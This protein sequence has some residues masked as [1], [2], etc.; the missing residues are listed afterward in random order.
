M[1]FKLFTSSCVAAFSTLAI[2][3]TS[4]HA[5]PGDP[6]RGGSVVIPIHV[7]EPATYDCHATNSPAVMWRVSP[8]YSTLLKVN[9]ERS[10][11]VMGDLAKSWTVSSDHLTYRFTL[12][13]NVK[14]HDGSLLTST[15]V[16]ASFDRMRNPPQ[17]V[18]SLR[19]GM[20]ADIASIETPDPQTV[21]FKFSKLNA[22]ALQLLA[23]PFGCI[24]SAKLLA[25][26]ASYPG[27]RVVGSGPFKF[28]RHTPGAEWV[29]E[30]FDDYFMPGRPYL[31]GFR[32][33]SVAPVSATNALI[34]GQVNYTMQGLTSAEVGRVTAARGDKVVVVGGAS[35]TAFLPWFAMNTQRDGLKDER[36]RRAL[37]L[38]LDRWGSSKPMEQLTPMF[39]VGGLV[40]PGSTFARSDAELT[41]LPGFGRDIEAARKESRRLLAAAG[42]KNLKITLVNNRA[43]TFFGV[44]VADQLRQVGVT[45]DH[46]PLDTPQV[47]AR[48]V[49]GD[50]DL[51]FD[52][53]AEYVDDPSIQLS[54]FE[55]FSTNRG[56]LARVGDP[57]F[58]DK[59]QSQMREINAE[60]RRKKVQD[61]EAYLME[62]S[63]VMPLFWQVRK[64]VIDSQLRGLGDPPS[65]Y[66]KLDLNDIWLDTAA[67]K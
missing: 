8:H 34:S 61:L 51:I 45:V 35:A 7:G 6:V 12:N 52:S 20:L 24:Y 13:A 2:C 31:D 15:D 50:Y 28:V 60:S 30:R 49:S 14:F 36:V 44:F 55:P 5:A 17:G 29:G 41:K 16:K 53:P 3:A 27:K 1:N 10:P 25:S 40:R 57:T 63:Y 22:A 56:N 59:Y 11:E 19:Q 37:N 32:M 62:K 9:A 42:Q 26:D 43:F 58:V 21:V 47:A 48:R 4:A 64:R 67:R 65:N 46:M 54:Y 39:K 33:P 66:L 23:S 38:A 18:V